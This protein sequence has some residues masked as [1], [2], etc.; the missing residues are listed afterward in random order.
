MIVLL[1]PCLLH[2]PCLRSGLAARMIIHLTQQQIASIIDVLPN[3]H[4]EKSTLTSLIREK[5]TLRVL[6]EV[7][8]ADGQ[9]S[10]IKDRFANWADD[11]TIV[12]PSEADA[13]DYRPSAFK[14][15]CTEWG[16]AG[17]IHRKYILKDGRTVICRGY[18][19]DTSSSGGQTVFY[20]TQ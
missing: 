13:L 15:V 12:Y 20:F 7:G 6:Y 1:S 18:W 3:D 17:Y 8:L 5:S 10:S 11:K 16:R 19:S 2:Q 14:D 4:P 9:E